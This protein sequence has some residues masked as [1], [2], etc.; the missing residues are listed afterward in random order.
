MKKSS[1]WLSV[2]PALL[3]L[4]YALFNAFRAGFAL[5]DYALAA[6]ALILLAL[7]IWNARLGA[8][9]ERMKE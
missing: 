9:L 1:I 5:L 7:L 3:L 6:A 4:G 2:A 8:K